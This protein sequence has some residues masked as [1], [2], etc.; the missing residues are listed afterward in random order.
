MSLKNYLKGSVGKQRRGPSLWK[1]PEEDGITFSLLSR[2]LVC[3]ERFRCLVINGLKPAERFSPAMDFGSMWHACEEA[4]AARQSWQE[5]LDKYATGLCLKYPMQRGEIDHW[6][7]IAQALFPLY[8]QHWEKH[9]DVW[10]RKP[11]L[12]EQIFDVPY[13]L[14]SGQKVRL[15]GKWDSVDLIGKGKEAGIYLQENKTK[16]TINR[17][18]LARQLTFDL[19]TMIYLVTLEAWINDRCQDDP[20]MAQQFSAPL[21]GIRYNVIRRSAHK[22]VESMLK[23][24]QEDQDNKRGD[25]W[26]LRFNVEVHPTAVQRFRKECL[27]PVLQQLCDWW[28]HIQMCQGAKITNFYGANHWRHP[29]GIYNPLNEGGSSDLDEYLF[30]G[31]E[32]GLR[33]TLDLF[34]ELK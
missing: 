8:V 6:Y 30:S 21:K 17:T 29:F 25:E 1:G 33:R 11:L 22:S 4:L 7:A 9:P 24:L 5:A 20:G 31:S 13:L 2:F 3:R 15:R 26:F 27:D 12:Q 10:N 34:P 19:Q 23:K 14:P 18:T 28:D 32:V 16:S